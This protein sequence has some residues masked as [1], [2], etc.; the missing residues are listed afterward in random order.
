MNIKQNWVGSLWRMINRSSLQDSDLTRTTDLGGLRVWIARVAWV[1]LV[2]ASLTLFIL[3]TL[4]VL[5][6]PLLP[7]SETEDSFTFTLEDLE[8]VRDIGLPE[9]LV[10]GPVNALFGMVS[11]GY[12]AIAGLI[13]WRRSNDWMALLVSFT[14]VSLGAVLFTG[15]DDAVRRAYPDLTILVDLLLNLSL[16]SLILLLY[17]FPNGRPVPPWTGYMFPGL[18]VL[19]FLAMFTGAYIA[20]LIVIF[21][22]LGVGV[23]ARV[24]RHRQVSSPLQRQQTRWVGLGLLGA[25]A[26]I[27]LSLFSDSVFP[28]D[29]PSA[30]RVIFLLAVEPVL[31]LLL[32]LPVSVG[33]AVLRYRLW[34]ID[35]LINRTVV[36][37][38]LTGVLMGLYIASIRLFQALFVRFLGEESNFAILLSTLVLAGAFMP[39]RLWLQALADRYFKETPDPTRELRSFGDQVQAMVQLSDTSQMARRLLDESVAA[40]RAESGAIF[41][42]QDGQLQLAQTSGAWDGQAHLTVPLKH[43]GTLIGQIT[44]GARRRNQA[45]SDDERRRLEEISGVAARALAIAQGTS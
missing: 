13:F 14:L 18:I 40:F 11:I 42:Q 26:I 45:Y 5:S 41:M 7:A 10:T 35:I 34:D 2:I 3:G 23:F 12:F 28:A 25:V 29:Q 39:V 1:V 20:I 4:E 19:M 16:L 21:L 22:L 8:V 33:I 37:G 30:G 9:W 15:A 6:E 43:E 17:L 44:L 32:L 27:A 38:P 31:V 36:Y 24:Y